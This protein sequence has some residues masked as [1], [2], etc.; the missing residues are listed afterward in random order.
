LLLKQCYINLFQIKKKFG[1]C[2]KTTNETAEQCV[3]GTNHLMALGSANGNGDGNFIVGAGTCFAR[4]VIAVI[5]A[6][7]FLA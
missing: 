7:P 2:I 4:F 1:C 5:D 6:I 3:I